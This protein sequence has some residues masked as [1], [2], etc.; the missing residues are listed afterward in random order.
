M[1]LSSASLPIILLVGLTRVTRGVGHNWMR[2]CVG[3]FRTYRA[4]MVMPILKR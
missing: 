2:G 4:S 3:N 1:Y